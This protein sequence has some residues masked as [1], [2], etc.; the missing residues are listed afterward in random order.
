MIVRVIQAMIAM[1]ACGYLF[2]VL[3]M[4]FTKLSVSSSIHNSLWCGA[5]LCLRGMGCLIGHL[6]SPYI[7]IYQSNY[8]VLTS[9][10]LVCSVNLLLTL[11][12]E[13]SFS[14]L[15]FSLGLVCTIIETA[16]QKV[17]I[18]L[19]QETDIVFV[20][21]NPLMF[22]IGSVICGLLYLV[23]EDD[24]IHLMIGAIIS[25][26]L[27][28]LSIIVETTTSE[29]DQSDW[30][31]RETEERVQRIP[32]VTVPH[33][34]L[35]PLS[36]IML[37][38]MMGTSDAFLFLWNL[39]LK[40]GNAVAVTSSRVRRLLLVAYISSTALGKI[41]GTYLS[42]HTHHLTLTLVFLLLS[43]SALIL[44]IPQVLVMEHRTLLF[45]FASTI[46]FGL[47]HG[48]L[49]P[50]LF[51]HHFNLQKPTRGAARRLISCLHLGSTVLPPLLYFLGEETALGPM[52]LIRGVALS[53]VL[54]LPL[55]YGI[56]SLQ[57]NNFHQNGYSSIPDP[58]PTSPSAAERWKRQL[59]RLFA[60]P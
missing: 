19:C 37:F 52:A 34:P 7:H 12:M 51:D 49:I 20:A 16:S 30:L 23:I 21:S 28:A 38:L 27:G 57:A 60:A 56:S 29:W 33:S 47:C 36:G 32:P 45:L 48:P 9:F 11:L 26:A 24:R 44:A 39:Y 5:L 13:T 22:G 25:L 50:F 43:T 18:N 46:L 41:F 1:A 4:I 42:N 8:T 15:F 6:V 31:L 40:R 55:L 17:V 10:L 14:Y 53:S 3:V 54:C 59:I 35:E 58:V 2:I